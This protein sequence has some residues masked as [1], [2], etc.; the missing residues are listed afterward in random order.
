LPVTF[1]VE[2][3]EGSPFPGAFSQELCPTGERC[4]APP[5]AL[6]QSSNESSVALRRGREPIWRSA[7]APTAETVTVRVSFESGGET[8]A[9]IQPAELTACPAN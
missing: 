4:L 9:L 7:P 3:P 2:T 1:S 8:Y 5:G 6:T